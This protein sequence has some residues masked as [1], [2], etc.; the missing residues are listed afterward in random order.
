MRIGGRRE[1]GEEASVVDWRGARR[2]AP[3][4]RYRRARGAGRHHSGMAR[5][6]GGA[7]RR[8]DGTDVG[9]GGWDAVRRGDDERLDERAVAD[10]ARAVAGAER[11]GRAAVVTADPVGV[12]AGLNLLPKLLFDRGLR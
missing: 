3:A 1:P 6:G 10:G 7:D 8:R 5:P 12:E 2:R 9:G 11:E 4:E